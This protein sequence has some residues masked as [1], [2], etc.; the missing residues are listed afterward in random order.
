VTIVFIEHVMPV[1]RD[2]ADRVIVMDYGKKI[3]EGSYAEVT[4]D[5]QVIAAYLGTE[6]EST[7][8]PA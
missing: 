8:A 4:G 2:L 1:V 5:P 3:A 6:N 7:E